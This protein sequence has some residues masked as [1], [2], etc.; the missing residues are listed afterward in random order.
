[1]TNPTPCAEVCMHG[2]DA[3]VQRDGT[4]L[5]TLLRASETHPPFVCDT[6]PTLND[7]YTRSLIRRERRGL[8]LWFRFT[9]DKWPCQ[10]LK[11][12]SPGYPAI[13][14]CWTYW[15]IICHS[16]ANLSLPPWQSQRA[17]PLTIVVPSVRSMALKA[18]LALGM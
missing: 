10:R 5:R 8:F 4:L 13:A 17:K 2:R 16:R 15:R 18:V 6:E 3:F 11:Q 7:G 9:A 12:P 1:M 14:I